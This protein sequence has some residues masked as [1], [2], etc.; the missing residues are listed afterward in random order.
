MSGSSA[1][2]TSLRGRSKTSSGLRVSASSSFFVRL[3][4]ALVRPP[5]VVAARDALLG[6]SPRAMR[7]R[8]TPWSARTHPR[9][10]NYASSVPRTLPCSTCST[11]GFARLGRGSRATTLHTLAGFPSANFYAP[12]PTENHRSG[13]AGADIPPTPRVSTSASIPPGRMCCT[14][15]SLMSSSSTTPLTTLSR[16]ADSSITPDP[17]VIR[18][19]VAPVGPVASRFIL[20]QAAA[21]NRPARAETVSRDL[22]DESCD[23]EEKASSRQLMN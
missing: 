11:C 21:L 17:P 7:R 18:S 22:V 9:A 23:D 6:A 1:G 3:V 4:A 14:Q 2:A 20:E 10:S 8:T 12:R 19:A 15:L 5:G 13:A 16:N